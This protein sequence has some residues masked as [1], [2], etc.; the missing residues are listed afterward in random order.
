[1]NHT[2]CRIALRC[3][4]I[5]SAMRYRIRLVLVFALFL[6]ADCT[7]AAPSQS[8][9]PIELIYGSPFPGAHFSTSPDLLFVN[10]VQ[11]DG[12]GRLS[13][14]VYDGGSLITGQESYAEI[15]KGIV[16]F[17]EGICAYIASGF[18]LHKLWPLLTYGLSDIKALRQIT[19]DIYQKFPEVLKE[20]SATK[21]LISTT[22]PSY[23]LL[24]R[25]PVRTIDDLKGMKLRTVSIYTPVFRALGAEPV[26]MSMTE[27]YATL[28]KGVLDGAL[29]SVADLKGLKLANIVKY[30]T[31]VNLSNAPFGHKFMNL[32]SWNNLPSD[33]R[34]IFNDN[35]KYWESE[36]DQVIAK[37][38]QDGIDYG[39]TQGVEFIT[40]SDAEYAKFIALMDA[41]MRKEAAKV[42]V[43]GL[44]GSKIFA[45]VRSLVEKYSE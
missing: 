7:A 4:F 18:Y 26:N 14:K 12:N 9:K 20:Y 45:E 44:P 35:L 24:T 16:D 19:N 38:T 27:A 28:E 17:G 41:E 39:K 10:K 8:L 31:L 29:A 33:V 5:E 25:K 32:N 3:T 6:L 37:V 22:P 2:I 30:A 21:H 34:K 13:I 15:A 40:F 23:Q 36:S 43:Q 11:K 42:D 1:M